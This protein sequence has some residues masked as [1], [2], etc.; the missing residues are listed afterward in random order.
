MATRTP[1]Q[2][3]QPAAPV[4]HGEPDGPCSKNARPLPEHCR[5]APSV[6]IPR[7]LRS[8]RLI[9]R[10]SA[11]PSTSS[12]HRSGSAAIDPAGIG[13]LLRTKNRETGVITPLPSSERRT[14]RVSGFSL[15]TMKSA[16]SSQSGRAGCA[17]ASRAWRLLDPG[18]PSRGW[19]PGSATVPPAMR[20]AFRKSRRFVGVPGMSISGGLKREVVILQHSERDRGVSPGAAGASLAPRR[21][22]EP[23]RRARQAPGCRGAAQGRGRFEGQCC[24]RSRSFRRAS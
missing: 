23:E 24:E 11:T 14:S 21:G 8:A 18:L 20:M 6:S 12:I 13:R 22:S 16:G 10:G 15:C 4:P 17:P 19:Q 1:V 5:T 9:D 3:A 2:S 7:P